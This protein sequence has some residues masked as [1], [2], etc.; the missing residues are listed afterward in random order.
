M[1]HSGRS[2]LLLSPLVRLSR[3]FA[4]QHLSQDLFRV[5]QSFGHVRVLVLEG[6]V[7]GV[8]VS[9]LLLVQEDYDLLL[10][11]QDYLGVV[12]ENDLHHT[13]A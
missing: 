5:Q 4:I 6:V 7:Q 3:L 9:V 11:I 8:L 12:L 10:T 2:H 1:V 13:V